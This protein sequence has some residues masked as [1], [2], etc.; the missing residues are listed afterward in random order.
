M[1]RVLQVFGMV[2]PVLMAGCAE[3]HWKVPYPPGEQASMLWSRDARTKGWNGVEVEYALLGAGGVDAI[4][5]SPDGRQHLTEHGRCWYEDPR[6]NHFK[7]YR[8]GLLWVVE[9]NGREEHYRFVHYP[10]VDRGCISV[11][12]QSTTSTED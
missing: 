5:R 6:G 1:T 12:E 9:F 11:V 4:V 3:S 7:S 10:R 8:D 2:V